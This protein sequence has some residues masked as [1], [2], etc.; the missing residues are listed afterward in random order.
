[1]QL[2]SDGKRWTFVACLLPC[3]LALGATMVITPAHAGGFRRVAYGSMAPVQS[4]IRSI[5]DQ[6]QR[7]SYA[8]GAI[9]SRR[10]SRRSKH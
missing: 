2:R 5:R 6:I 10:Y 4:T 7:E 3:L 8:S 1:M 9:A